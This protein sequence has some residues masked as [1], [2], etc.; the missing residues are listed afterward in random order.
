R[1]QG[2]KG[3][4]ELWELSEVEVTRGEYENRCQALFRRGVE[5][6]DRLLKELDLEPDEIDEVV[7]VGGMTR[8]PRVRQMLKEHLGVKRLNI[9]IDPDV[10]V[11][12]G[13]A[14]V[15]H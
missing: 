4:C 10:V 14:S 3:D 7:M 11:A 2:G 13:A 1:A 12:Y 9:E 8:T 5:P 15:A 6:V